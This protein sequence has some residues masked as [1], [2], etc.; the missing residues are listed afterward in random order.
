MNASLR[1]SLT[2]AALLL[3]LC[4]ALAS[5][6]SFADS[7]SD[8]R[9]QFTA[10]R[11]E[12]LDLISAYSYTY[13]A[14]DVSR[15]LDLFTNDARWAW[16][17]GP[18]RTLAVSLPGKQAM[19]DYFAPRLAALAQQGIQSRHFQ[20]NT[21]F[22]SFNGREASA[23]TYVLVTWQYAGELVPRPVH[24]GYYEDKF[25]RTPRGW[26]FKERVIYVDHV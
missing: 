23:K 19:N 5:S 20:T 11:Q 14:K 12:I 10:A 6:T 15:W 1:A 2:P 4:A 16:Y 9:S 26:K 25:I 24:T 22:T 18:Q 17:A 7:R 3:L 13:D 21:V 8:P